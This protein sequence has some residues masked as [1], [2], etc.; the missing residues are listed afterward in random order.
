MQHSSILALVC[1]EIA[2]L[3]INALQN[4]N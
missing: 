4:K 3:N 2:K 1:S